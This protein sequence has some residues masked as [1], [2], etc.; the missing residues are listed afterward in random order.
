LY[1]VAHSGEDAA[2]VGEAFDDAGHGVVGED[3]VLKIDVAGV[4]D[5]DEGFED[6]QNGHDAGTDGDLTVSGIG[7]GEVLHVH[8]EEAGAGFMD[9]V[10][11]VGS[12]AHGVAYVDAAAHAWVQAL[13]CGEHGEWRGPDFV[14][15]AVVVDGEADIVFL[16]E[17]FDGGQAFGQRVAGDDDLYAGGLGIVE[18]L[19]EVGWVFEVDGADGGDLDVGRGVCGQ[20][21]LLGCEGRHGQVVF[22]VFAV[23]GGEMQLLDGGDDLGARHIA[24]GVAGEAEAD[25]RW[26]CW[27]RGC[28]ELGG[29]QRSCGGEDGAG[30]QEVAAAQGR[31]HGFH[32][33]NGTRFD[34]ASSSQPDE[35][36]AARLDVLRG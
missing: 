36:I 3:F 34:P 7:L 33:A 21:F 29:G 10:D 8:V 1:F 11:Y 35:Q 27:W 32:A 18:V 28:K 30:A 9:G 20:G 22:G 13:H 6:L 24:K 16:H 26:C 12:G 19:A 15:G 31:E 14:L 25:G 5:G 4:L 2:H 17:L 23:D